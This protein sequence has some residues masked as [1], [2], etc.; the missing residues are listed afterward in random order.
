MKTMEEIIEII[1][2]TAAELLCDR[3]G[4]T[5]LYIPKVPGAGS[6]LVLAIGHASALA[7]CQAS[8]GQTFYLPSRLSLAR[9][10]LRSAVLYDLKR[11]LST[12]EIAIRNGISTQHIRN[13]RNQEMNTP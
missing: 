12:N 10:R 7:L 8:A 1:G 6:R 5:S 13:I 3:L 2:E 4:G 9:R 11:G